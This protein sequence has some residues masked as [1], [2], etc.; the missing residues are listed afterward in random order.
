MKTTRKEGL[1]EV[2][3]YWQCFYDREGNRWSQFSPCAPVS[4]EDDKQLREK[5]GADEALSPNMAVFRTVYYVE[6]TTDWQA[7]NTNQAT[8]YADDPDT[9]YYVA[10]E[11]RRDRSGEWQR[12]SLEREVAGV[13]LFESSED[14]IPFDDADRII[15]FLK[16]SAFM[17][18]NTTFHVH[19]IRLARGGFSA[20]SDWKQPPEGSTHVAFLHDDKDAKGEERCDAYVELTNNTVRVLEYDIMSN[21][22]AETRGRARSLVGLFLSVAGSSRT[23]SFQPWDNLPESMTR[24]TSEDILTVLLDMPR[25]MRYVMGDYGGERPP[26]EWSPRGAGRKPP[27]QPSFTDDGW[28]TL[29]RVEMPAA[30]A[31]RF[32]SAGPDKTFGTADDMT[33]TWKIGEK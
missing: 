5:A 20:E 23:D 22:V 26:F 10:L 8:V 15:R 24:M 3:S 27:E 29:F 21:A 31:I 33:R 4:K 13:W 2:P 7:I 11:Y 16:T 12:V 19:T 18:T 9:G 1:R 25:Y 6:S 32:T 30:D 28:G 17:R 14:R